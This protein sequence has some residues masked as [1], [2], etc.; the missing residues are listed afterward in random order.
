MTNTGEYDGIVIYLFDG[1]KIIEIQD[2]SGNM[3][4]Q[5]IH[6]T[7]YI[8]ELV[9]MRAKDKGDLYVHQDANWNIVGLTDLGGRVGE[10]Y[11]NTPYGPVTVHQGERDQCGS[12]NVYG[13]RNGDQDVDS[14]NKG[15]R[16]RPA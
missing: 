15:T 2:G 1:Q 11:V 4:Q 5:L 8:D 14:T 13:D 7:R 10:S 9:I 16:P 6:G 3:V 12:V